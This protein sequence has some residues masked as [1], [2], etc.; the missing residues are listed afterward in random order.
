M[1]AEVLA[2]RKYSHYSDVVSRGLGDRVMMWRLSD[3]GSDVWGG[4]GVGTE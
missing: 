4:G 2:E 1:A 3:V